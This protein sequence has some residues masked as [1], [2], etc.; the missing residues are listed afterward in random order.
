MAGVQRPFL[1]CPV[2]KGQTALPYPNLEGTPTAHTDWPSATW[3]KNFLRLECGHVFVGTALCIHWRGVPLLGQNPLPSD[4][5]VGIVPL[6]CAS[7]RCPELLRIHISVAGWRRGQGLDRGTI[8]RIVD[9]IQMADFPPEVQ[10]PNG[11]P[12]GQER[13]RPIDSDPLWWK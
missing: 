6:P 4:P 3:K 7:E 2:C 5:D 8:L 9:V 1:E 12:V 11:Y 10:C 13:P